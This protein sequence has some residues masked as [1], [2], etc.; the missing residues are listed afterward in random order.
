MLVMGD[1]YRFFNMV[2]GSFLLYFPFLGR[3]Q[4]LFLSIF[5]L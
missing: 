3:R 1:L 2:E 5:V 4:E